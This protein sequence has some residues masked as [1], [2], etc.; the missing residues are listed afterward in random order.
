MRRSGTM[1]LPQE[2]AEALVR[3]LAR[4]RATRFFRYLE[5]LAERRHGLKERS[6]L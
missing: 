4:Y 6:A 2:E 1:T 5:Q 3:V